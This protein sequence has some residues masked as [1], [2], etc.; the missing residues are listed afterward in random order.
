MCLKSKRSNPH[1]TAG[2][3]LTLALCGGLIGPASAATVRDHRGDG[4]KPP[5]QASAGLPCGSVKLCRKVAT[6]RDHRTG[7]TL[8]G[9]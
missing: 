3:L 4:P 6:V 7:A 2:L 5:P 1:T 8:P 9:K